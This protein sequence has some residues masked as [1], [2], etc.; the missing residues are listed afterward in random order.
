MVGLTPSKACDTATTTATIRPREGTTQPAVLAHGL[1]GGFCRD[2][3][4]CIVTE[5]MG[6]P[7]GGCVTIQSLYRDK[8]A[9][10]LRACH[11]T[12]DCI[13][14]GGQR[15][16][17]WACRDT[18][19]RHGRACAAIRPGRRA[20]RRSTPATRPATS[21]D[22]T[23]AGPRHGAVR[24]QPGRSARAAWAQCAGSLGAV[25]AAWVHHARSQGPLGVHQCTQP[26][27]GLSA[28][29]LSHCLGHCS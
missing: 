27:F 11:D 3:Q 21:C 2:T 24:G 15:L 26:S 13:V 10:W 5:A 20:A 23:D 1:A 9:V 25:R 14:T 19:L 7:P 28:L 12:I 4:Y 29:F 18:M 17:R 8:R 6:W 16:G 22:T